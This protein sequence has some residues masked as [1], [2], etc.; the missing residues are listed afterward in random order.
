MA[1]IEGTI[2]LVKHTF[3]A[4]KLP[5]RGLFRMTCLMVGSA[6]M[7]NAWRI[8]HYWEEKRKVEMQKILTEGGSRVAPEQQSGSFP[9][10][11]KALFIGQRSFLELQTHALFIGVL[12]LQCDHVLYIDIKGYTDKLHPTGSFRPSISQ[13]SIRNRHGE[14]NIRFVFSNSI[15]D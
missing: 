7:I 13:Y 8:H 9:F 14:L 12:Y 1:A 6:A 10:F 15:M 11:L 5:V 3:P 2:L 4:V